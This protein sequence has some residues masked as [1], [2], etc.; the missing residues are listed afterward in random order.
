MPVLGLWVAG[1]VSLVCEGHSLSGMG[2]LS[3]HQ[4][5]PL[6][7]CPSE[8]APA[9]WGSVAAV[10]SQFLFSTLPS[11]APALWSG[12]KTLVSLL[13]VCGDQTWDP[14]GQGVLLPFCLVSVGTE[15]GY[16]APGMPRPLCT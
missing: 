7:Q 6:Y 3:S 1:V 15:L 2:S 13:A 4:V 9:L 8:L 12:A 14:P 10:G 5:P 16:P 11:L